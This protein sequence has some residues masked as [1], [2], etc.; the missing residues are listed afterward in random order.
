MQV[1]ERNP[2]I[3]TGFTWHTENGTRMWL[4]AECLAAPAVY[5]YMIPGKNQIKNQPRMVE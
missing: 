5:L 3:H 2:P 4:D 1:K